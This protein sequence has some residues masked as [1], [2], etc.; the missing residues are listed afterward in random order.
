MCTYYTNTRWLCHKTKGCKVEGRPCRIKPSFHKPPKQRICCNY[1]DRF[2]GI[3]YGVTC[4]GGGRKSNH[5][6]DSETVFYKGLECP[7]HHH[8]KML[9]L[10]RLWEEEWT[11][12]IIETH[13]TKRY[14]E[15]AE[16]RK[17]DETANRARLIQEL[18]EDVKK[19]RSVVLFYKS[20]MK[21]Q[22]IAIERCRKELVKFSGCNADLA[23]A[24]DVVVSRQGR[25]FRR[26]LKP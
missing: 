19:G 14:R 4:Q 7:W 13:L 20:V 9:S 11:E 25:V 26:Y 17:H 15:A 6:I 1:V 12:Q 18:F 24:D 8:K 23:L 3:C 16:R 21:W 22:T 5:F 10:E 2:S